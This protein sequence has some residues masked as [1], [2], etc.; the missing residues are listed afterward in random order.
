[1]KILFDHATIRPNICSHGPQT[2]PWWRW[3][4]FMIVRLAV[5]PPSTGWRLW[6]YLRRR[7]AYNLDLYID[8]RGSLGPGFNQRGG[9]PWTSK[10]DV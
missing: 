2:W 6:I 9:T 4:G 10:E 8:R 1:M 3:C 7:V 5:H